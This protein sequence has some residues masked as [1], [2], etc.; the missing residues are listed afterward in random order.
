MESFEY[1]NSLTKSVSFVT[2][3]LCVNVIYKGAENECMTA[4]ATGTEILLYALYAFCC[5]LSR[6]AIYVLNYD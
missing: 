6:T 3:Y 4:R 5:N 2:V 1:R